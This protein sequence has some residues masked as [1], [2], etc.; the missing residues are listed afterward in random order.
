MTIFIYE[1]LTSGALS[2]EVFSESLMHEGELM[3]ESLCQDLLAYGHKIAMMRDDRL[4]AFALSTDH[5]TTYPVQSKTEFQ[6]TWQQC[7]QQYDVFLLIAP[8]TDLILFNLVQQLEQQA[9][10]VLNCSSEAILLCTNKYLSYQHFIENQIKTPE[11]FVADKW[12]PL[13]HSEQQQW[14]IK[15]IDGAGSEDTYLCHSADARQLLSASTKHQFIVQPYISGQNL[16]LSLFITHDNLYLLSV[17]TQ[18]VEQHHQRLHIDTFE[19]QRFDLLSVEHAERVANQVSRSIEGLWGFVGIDLIKTDETVYIIEV[20]PRLTT[21]Y[22]ESNMRNKT[23]P[24]GFLNTQ[25]E[26]LLKK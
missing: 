19:A 16:S 2:E 14:V 17:N 13:T 5:I 10:T 3:L 26:A 6:K 20:N 12:L 8:E 24:A 7:Q 21:T 4:P 11:T 1:Y 23:N 18:H 15:P 9:K 25:L 22:A